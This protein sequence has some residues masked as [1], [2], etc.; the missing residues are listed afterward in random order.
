[1]I[2]ER[3]KPKGCPGTVSEVCRDLKCRQIQICRINFVSGSDVATEVVAKQMPHTSV[4][5]GHGRPTLF[6]SRNGCN[7]P[8]N[9][10]K[11]R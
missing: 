1:M 7:G 10:K 5:I 4:L 11:G 2:G 3:P 6:G 8:G 9:R